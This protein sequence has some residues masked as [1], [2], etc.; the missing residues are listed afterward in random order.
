[1][2]HS[3]HQYESRNRILFKG[4]RPGCEQNKTAGRSDPAVKGEFS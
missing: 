3:M 4:N 2:V 1:M